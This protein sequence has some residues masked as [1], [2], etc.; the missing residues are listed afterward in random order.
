MP[1][2]KTSLKEGESYGPLVGDEVRLI[3]KSLD[4]R[5]AERLKYNL[6]WMA[7]QL[8]RFG[9]L[10]LNDRLG[11]KL[12]TVGISTIKPLVRYPQ[13]RLYKITFRKNLSR[14]K[15][16]LYARIP[17]KKI[18]WDT[19][20][21]GHFE[22][23]TVHHCGDSSNGSLIY[24]LQLVDVTTGWSEITA[25]YGNEFATMKDGFDYLLARLPFL[26][27]EFHPDNGPEFVNQ[28]LIKH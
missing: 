24:T 19:L 7:K 1:I 14:P 21:P 10:T 25:I 2:Q 23:D 16:R 6:V 15:N 8:Y 28:F 27:L 9:E 5:C 20:T 22:V 26:V 4:Y 18:T 11:G 3:G 12:E 17:V 13:R